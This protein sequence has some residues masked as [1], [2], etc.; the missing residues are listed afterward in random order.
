MTYSAHDLPESA[1]PFTM[2]ATDEEGEETWSI[3]VT[4][5]G[6]VSI[7]G[8]GDYAGHITITTTWGDGTVTSA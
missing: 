6:V 5:P 2:V 1:F 7:P 8:K 4:E 3:T